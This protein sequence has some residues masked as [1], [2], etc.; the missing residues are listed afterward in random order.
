MLQRACEPAAGVQ[1]PGYAASIPAAD[2]LDFM[3][4]APAYSGLAAAQSCGA[5]PFPSDD[6]MCCN[7]SV[8]GHEVW[9]AARVVRTYGS[10]VTRCQVGTCSWLVTCLLCQTCR[11]YRIGC[12]MQCSPQCTSDMHAVRQGHNAGAHYCE[13]H[14]ACAQD[15]SSAMDE[16]HNNAGSAASVTVAGQAAD[17]KGGQARLA[18]STRPPAGSRGA[19]AAGGSGSAADANRNDAAAEDLGWKEKYLA[20]FT[21]TLQLEFKVWRCRLH[22]KRRRAMQPCLELLTDG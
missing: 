15:E 21:R 7:P 20:L 12:I 11:L 1:R 14:L 16:A 18:W 5:L 9:L 3:A 17:V 2:R 10:S 22:W 6:A 4:A 13:V 8:T 19:K